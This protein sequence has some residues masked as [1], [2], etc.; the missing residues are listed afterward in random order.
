MLLIDRYILA[1]FFVNF[2]LLFTLLFLFAVAIDLAVALEDFVDA[3]RIAAG[4]D[5]GPAAVLAAFTRLALSFQSPRFFQFF[6]YLHGLVAIG[7]MGFTLAQMYRHR[8]LV[9]LLSAGLGMHRIAMPFVVGM[10]ALSIVQ[11]CNQEFILP[12]VATLL[13]RDHG[14]IGQRTVE[15]FALALTPDGGGNLFQSPR[16]DPAR[17][18][19]FDLT[20]LERDE[21]GRTRR[22]VT[23]KRAVWSTRAAVDGLSLT[24]G[25]A[26]VLREVGGEV[27]M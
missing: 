25:G 24:D 9:A 1:R 23:A 13:L 20:I 4:D 10:F 7:A 19:L 6:A 5:A 22:R 15:E 27:A 3:A 26:V 12:R 21:R 18:E 14:Q 11:L 2:A 17:N 8:E 16:F